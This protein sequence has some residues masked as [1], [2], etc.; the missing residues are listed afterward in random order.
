MH[1]ISVVG[2]KA[3]HNI[4]PTW[5]QLMYAIRNLIIELQLIVTD[6]CKDSH[7]G[8]LQRRMHYICSILVY[9]NGILVMPAKTSF[10]LKRRLRH[11]VIGVIIIHICMQTTH[12]SCSEWYHVV[13]TTIAMPPALSSFASAHSNVKVHQSLRIIIIS[14][15]SIQFNSV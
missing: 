8:T 11:I 3:S 7:G 4:C 10:G 14:F 5:Q 1:I 6:E 2:Y 15:N 12:G 13:H 9:E